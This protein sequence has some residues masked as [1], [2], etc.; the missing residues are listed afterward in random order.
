M[1]I[2]HICLC[3]PVT[4]GWNYQDNMIT[5]Y[6]KK[7]GHDVTII[8]SQWI[9]G[10]NNKL[11]KFDESNYINSDGVKV[12][13]LPIKG[14][15]NFERKFKKYE[16]LYES[17]FN[18]NP[19]ILF[20]H[21]ISFID[22]NIIIKYLKRNKDK[23][24]K[25][26]VDNH[27]DYSNS[28]TSWV[29]KNILHGIIWKMMA[30]MIKPYTTKFYGVTPARVDFLVDLYKLP[31]EKV[32]LLVMGADDEKVKEV[33]DSRLIENVRKEYGIKNTDF[34]IVTGGKIDEAKTQTLLLMEA[35]NKIKRDDVKLIVFGSVS[36]SLKDK[37]INLCDDTKVKY[38]GWVNAS[39][40]YKYFSI[41]DLVVF[42]GRHSVFWE[43]VVAQGKPMICKYWEGTTHVDVGGNTKFLQ[44]DSIEEI[45]QMIKN[46]L[47]SG[48]EY[49]KMKKI[50]QEKGKVEF[51]YENI[52]RKSIDM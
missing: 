14:K 47:D 36:E 49:M 37:F 9:W 5:K 29:S 41:A 52:A 23:D 38:L 11:K 15:D 45:Y 13:R 19:D 50:A 7:L 39:D 44:E 18:E 43:Q 35:V 31:R 22:M 51:S 20:I 26:F 42:P 25:V 24:I 1:K 2:V 40:S 46:L 27:S 28:A 17:I 33:Q 21:N 32:N 48:D 8:T 16:N 4:D 34:L 6:H 3:G 30:N 10:E 12:I